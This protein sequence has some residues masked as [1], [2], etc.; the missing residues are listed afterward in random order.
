MN[1]KRRHKRIMVKGIHG[2][3]LFTSV[4]EIINLS[5]GGAAIQVSKSL[6]IGKEYL[7]KLEDSGKNIGLKSIV[8]WSVLK[9]SQKGPHGDVIPVYNAGVKFSDIL[10]S[11]S[12]ELLD[13]IEEHKIVEDEE[14]LKGLRFKIHTTK[15]T[16]LYVPADYKVK[17]ISL[18]G[19]LI[20]TTQ[21]FKPEE[22]F[23]LDIFLKGGRDV[24]CTGRIV[25]CMEIKGS[26]QKHYDIG[27]EFLE[28]RQEDRANLESFIRS[29][30]ISEKGEPE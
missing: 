30:S 25:T 27:V 21:S 17:L 10:N 13:F 6:T 12:S 15:N 4:V 14:R 5:L 7:I 16:L 24:K 22:Q 23:P 20:E 9:G 29:I 8:I 2:N 11:K 19:M 3:V 18:S 28:M 26:P 1:D